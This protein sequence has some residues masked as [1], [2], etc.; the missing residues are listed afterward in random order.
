MKARLWR[1]VSE[2]PLILEEH[3][4]IRSLLHPRLI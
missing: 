4:E 2:M 3:I 1:Q